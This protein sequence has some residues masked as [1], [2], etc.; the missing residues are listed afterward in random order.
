MIQ[1]V[2]YFIEMKNFVAF[3]PCIFIILFLYQHIT[4]ETRI[5]ICSNENRFVKIF[6]V[7]EFRLKNK[8]EPYY[9][10]YNVCLYVL[11]KHDFVK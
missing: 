9:C 1:N 11:S 3:H 7:L 4:K 5:H 10:H 8:T 6:N 2:I